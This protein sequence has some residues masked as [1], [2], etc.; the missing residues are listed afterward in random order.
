MPAEVMPDELG[1]TYGGRMASPIWT[2]VCVLSTV[3]LSAGSVEAEFACPGCGED[4]FEVATRGVVAVTG[5][6]VD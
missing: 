2:T 4:T 3:A 5:T 1:R 6:L